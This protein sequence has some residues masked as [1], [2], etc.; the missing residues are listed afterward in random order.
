MPR[1]VS[2]AYWY[3]ALS[4]HFELSVADLA[5]GIN[6][7]VEHVQTAALYV[8]TI[9][10]REAP[11]DRGGA[12]EWHGYHSDLGHAGLTDHHAHLL[13]AAVDQMQ[14]AG[15][16]VLPSIVQDGCPGHE[17]YLKATEWSR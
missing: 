4:A 17:D 8:N 3:A 14:S 11:P 5:Q 9:G 12:I 6:R 15:A 13:P 16:L 1:W 2:T 10:R 7:W